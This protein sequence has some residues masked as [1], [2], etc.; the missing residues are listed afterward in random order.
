MKIKFLLISA[1]VFCFFVFGGAKATKAQQF[2]Q[3]AQTPESTAANRFFPDALARILLRN[4]P[5]TIAQ[6]AFYEPLYTSVFPPSPNN[7]PI[8][9]AQGTQLLIDYANQDPFADPQAA[10]A[11]YNN[12]AMRA[13]V[14]HPSIG[15][16]I[17]S[18]QG[19]PGG[20]EAIDFYVNQTNS[21]GFPKVAGV[22]YADAPLQNNINILVLVNSTTQ[23]VA[24][25]IDPQLI[26]ENPL[27]F[28]PLFKHEVMH[29]DNLGGFALYE[30]ATAYT[31]QALDSQLLL[32]HHPNLALLN[33]R[34]TYT[35]RVFAAALSN[36][37]SLNGNRAAMGMLGESNQ[38]LFP[39]TMT[40][41]TKFFDY[42]NGFQ[43]VPS[44]GNTELGFYQSE[45]LGINNCQ[46]Q[47]FNAA[48][49]QCLDQA[50]A[51]SSMRKTSLFSPTNRL[52]QALTLRLNIFTAIGNVSAEYAN[53]YVLP[54]AD[55]SEKQQL[56][57]SPKQ[58][59]APFASETSLQELLKNPDWQIVSGCEV[60][61]V[62]ARET[63]F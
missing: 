44:P 40:T 45:F 10:L 19:T 9:E 4:R 41:G 56:L 22:F 54:P 29:Q 5:F 53:G 8:T 42:V 23:Q 18:L 17:A 61:S 58:P 36:S 43:N 33:S 15:V 2:L 6:P 38:P 7:P 16:A 46:T 28:R 34:L 51:Q 1:I 60:N 52:Q 3:A 31:F 39:G 37:K 48:Q 30:E 14:S 50:V 20:D 13:K 26:R 35:N 63:K 21:L 57:E 24:Y 11:V 12:P 25:V 59:A 32:Q 55:L 27:L 62:L 49:F 47:E